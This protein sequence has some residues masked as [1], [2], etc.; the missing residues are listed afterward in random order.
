VGGRR[1]GDAATVRVAARIAVEIVAWWAL[2]VGV[3]VVTLSSVS[4]PELATAAGAGLI[5]AVA[6]AAAR[7]IIAE[8]WRPDWRWLRWLPAVLA[9]VVADT[10]RAFA[11]AARHLRARQVP[12]RFVHASLDEPRTGD[13]AA[14]A[15][16]LAAATLAVSVTPGSFV[17]DTDRPGH[18]ITVHAITE[19]RPEL[20][21][22]VAR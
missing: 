22:V 13:P 1:G 19:G 3:W 12:G 10:W 17:L 18:R 11:V 16:H 4:A 6:T 14:R 9:A 21:R 8:S 5:C 20:D 7:R 15:A 2:L